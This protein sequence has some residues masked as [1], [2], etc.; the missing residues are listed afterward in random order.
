[1]DDLHSAIT[2]IINLVGLGFELLGVA[3]IL[4]GV[5]RALLTYIRSAGQPPSG[6]ITPYRALRN[7]IGMALLLGLELLVAADI[8]RTVAIDPSFTSVGILALL[9]FV[10][11][12]LSWTLTLEIEERWPWQRRAEANP[13]APDV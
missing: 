11:T 1:M 12:F 7:R 9:V 4:V 2:T 3:I 5:I 6:P 10:R 13:H 8:V